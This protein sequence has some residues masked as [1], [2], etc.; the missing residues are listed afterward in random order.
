MIAATHN[1]AY[2][3]LV[4][5]DLRPE[6]GTD[7]LSQT[8]HDEKR[9]GRG[10]VLLESVGTVEELQA[11]VAAGWT[12]GR[13]P[14]TEKFTFDAYD[15]KMPPGAEAVAV[16]KSSGALLMFSSAARPAVE[17]G[18]TMLTLLLPPPAAGEAEQ[19]AA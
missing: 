7:R 5:A 6:L 18:D 19:R 14:I 10:R 13:T 17:P 15:F 12:F 2:N 4:C 9:A 1:D 8:G 16:L 11:R 3:S